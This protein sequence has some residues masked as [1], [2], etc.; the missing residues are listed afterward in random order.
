MVGTFK[1]GH[2]QSPLQLAKERRQRL[3]AQPPSIS[4]NITAEERKARFERLNK[5]VVIPAPTASF[6]H[7]NTTNAVHSYYTNSVNHAKD[8]FSSI[9][10]GG[11][12]EGGEEEGEEDEDDDELEAEDEEFG[13]DSQSDNEIPS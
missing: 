8:P 1:A 12:G 11:G 9:P 4:F 6:P 3:G 7:E 2:G 5:S 10:G 13:G